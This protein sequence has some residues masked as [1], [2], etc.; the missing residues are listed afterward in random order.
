M[1]P[2]WG[3]VQGEKPKGWRNQGPE[4]QSLLSLCF[5]GRRGW[6]EWCDIVVVT[7]KCEVCSLMAAGTLLG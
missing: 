4:L 5:T 2:C 7:F 3:L 1:L 6:E